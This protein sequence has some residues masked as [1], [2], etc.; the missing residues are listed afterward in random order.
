MCQAPVL[1]NGSLAELETS[2][3]FSRE[4]I[5]S[6]TIGVEAVGRW[7]QTN[8]CSSVLIGPP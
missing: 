2:G 7:T 1:T 8:K 5:T 3:S 4:I 6:I